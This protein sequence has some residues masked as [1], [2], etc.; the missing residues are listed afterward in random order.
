MLYLVRIEIEAID[1][2]SREDIEESI[3]NLIHDLDGIAVDEI[4][5]SN[6]N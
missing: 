1:G 5:V 6:I 2:Q 3:G 4:T